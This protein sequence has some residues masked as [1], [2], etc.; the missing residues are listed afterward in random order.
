ME[1]L[2]S[3]KI[4][5]SYSNEFGLEQYWSTFVELLWDFAFVLPV[6]INIFLIIAYVKCRKKYQWTLGRFLKYAI[7]GG[8]LGFFIA[9]VFVMTWTMTH[10]AAQGPLALIWFGPFFFAIG[11]LAGFGLFAWQEARKRRRVQ[12]EA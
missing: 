5:M 4:F 3:F 2:A 9:F 6:V 12:E 1:R 10:N 7:Y 8:V 11:E